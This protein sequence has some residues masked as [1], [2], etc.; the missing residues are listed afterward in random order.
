MDKIEFRRA[1]TDKVMARA[2]SGFTF[3]PDQYINIGGN[4]YRVVSVSYY[5]RSGTPT[6]LHVTAIVSLA[7]F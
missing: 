4:D 2:E 3:K 7:E 6:A 1:T 5:T